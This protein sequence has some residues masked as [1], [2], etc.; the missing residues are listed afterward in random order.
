LC[1]NNKIG[2]RHFGTVFF[3][4]IFSMY[5]RL[6]IFQVSMIVGRIIVRS[7]DAK[8]ILME[9]ILMKRKLI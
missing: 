6:Q 3:S 7:I 9:R 8:R 1:L 2:K 5:G 4:I